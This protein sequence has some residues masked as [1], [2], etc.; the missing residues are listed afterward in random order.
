[1]DKNVIRIHAEYFA[2]NPTTTMI[3]PISEKNE[4][5]ARKI[6]NSPARTKLRNKKTSRI[7]PPSWRYVDLSVSVRFGSPPKINFFFDEANA[8]ARSIRSPPTTD[9]LF[10]YLIFGNFFTF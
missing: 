4:T 1:M 10:V 5:T 2:L 6:E 8:S 3:H 9:K 7:R